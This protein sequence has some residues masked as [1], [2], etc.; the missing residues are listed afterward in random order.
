MTGRLCVDASVAAKWVLQESGSERATR[1]LED[2]HRHGVSLV[3][4]PHLRVEV[5]S[6]IYKHYRGGVI[7]LDEARASLDAFNEIHLD[8]LYPPRLAQRAVELSV[9]FGWRLPYDAFYLALGE[10]ADCDVWTADRSLFRAARTRYPRLHL[11][12]DHPAA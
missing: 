5:A 6:A 7:T 3:G 1:L 2:A 10:I 11:L 4:P 9:E 8:L 12:P